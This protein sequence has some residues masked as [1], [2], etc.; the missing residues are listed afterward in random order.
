MK[1]K[2]AL[3]LHLGVGCIAVIL[4]LIL[5]FSGKPVEQFTGN[6]IATLFWLAVYYLFYHYLAP[7]F[8][9]RKKL[10]GFFVVSVVILLILPFIG[11]TLLFFTRALFEGNF[12]DFYKGYSPAMHLSGFKAMVLAGLT[13]SFFRLIVEYFSK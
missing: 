1:T 4:T 6:L 11:Y 10:I 2:V 13:G 5:L 8:L 7:A 12:S 3:A 9:L